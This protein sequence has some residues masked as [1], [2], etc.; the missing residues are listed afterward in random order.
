MTD[1]QLIIWAAG[2]FD[3]EGCVN[4]SV[5]SRVFTR[6]SGARYEQEYYGL[7]GIICQREKE[8]L[9]HL[10]RLFGGHLFPYEIHG[11]QYYRWHVWAD[12]ALNFFLA[13]LP[14]SIA[15]RSRLLVGIEYQEFKNANYARFRTGYPE[16][17]HDRIRSYY[18]QLKELNKRFVSPQNPNPKPGGAK[19]GGKNNFAKSTG[20]STKGAPE[21]VQ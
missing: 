7:H 15:K 14:F 17:V 21:I 3:G 8:P 13:I 1:E 10:H 4:I 11:N 5:S 9:E 16:W 20:I 18:A 19:R 2:F 12:G 6:K